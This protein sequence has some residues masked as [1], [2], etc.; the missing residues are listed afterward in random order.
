M[1]IVIYYTSNTS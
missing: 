1:S